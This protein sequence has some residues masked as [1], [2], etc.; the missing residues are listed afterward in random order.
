MEEGAVEYQGMINFCETHPNV[1]TGLS[2]GKCG[3]YICPRC[4]VQTPVGGRC[5]K[6]ARI[7]KSP[8]YDVKPGRYTLAIIAAIVVG[9]VT[10]V[11]WAVLLDAIGW[12]FFLPGLLA[13]GAGYVVGEVVSITANRKRGVGLALIA[14]MGVGVS[15]AVVVG[16]TLG[17]PGG[18]SFSLFDIA[19]AL[20]F[21]AL[22]VYIAVGRV[23]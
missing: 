6:C 18:Y 4:L 16:T 20:M 10:G 15:Y 23:R 2:C 17:R 9:G 1:E 7:R 19:F 12:I 11:V 5:S 22:A 21:L 14:A 13:A 8:V 3:R